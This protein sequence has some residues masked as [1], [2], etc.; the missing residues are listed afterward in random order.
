MN[1]ISPLIGTRRFYFPRLLAE[2]CIGR[3]RKHGRKEAELF[4]ALT[5]SLGEDDRTT[6]FRKALVPEQTCYRTP[7]GLLV[8]IDGEAIFRLNQQCYEAEEL[9]AGQIHAHPGQAYHSGADDALSLIKLPGGLSMVVP[10]FARGPLKPRRWSIY[11][12]GEDGQWGPRPRR[13][14]VKVK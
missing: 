6:V 1:G 9:L 12:L 11:R 14:K 13:V 7:E 5:A 4:I 3:M 8:T 10:D 2:D